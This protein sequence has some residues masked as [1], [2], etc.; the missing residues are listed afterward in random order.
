[1]VW[2]KNARCRR[3]TRRIA[4][5]VLENIL[6]L[7]RLLLHRLVREQVRL[8]VDVPSFEVGWRLLLRVVAHVELVDYLLGHLALRHWAQTRLRWLDGVAALTLL[9]LKLAHERIVV[10]HPVLVVH[11]LNGRRRFNFVGR[12]RL[13]VVVSGCSL[14]SDAVWVLPVCIR[15]V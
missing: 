2:R 4:Q 13:Q 8:L 11:L 12:P 3:S 14:P 10:N 6:A 1:M 7:A 9:E 5:E 15:L